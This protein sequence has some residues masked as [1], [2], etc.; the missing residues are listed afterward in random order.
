MLHYL[1]AIRQPSTDHPEAPLKPFTPLLLNLLA[2]SDQA[3]R[4]LALSTSIQIFSADSVPP[5]A[6]ADLK[7]Q[8]LKKDLTKKVQ[9]AILAGVLGE[10]MSLNGG[11]SIGDGMSAT[12]AEASTSTSSGDSRPLVRGPTTIPTI[13]PANAFP[14]EPLPGSA[15]VQAIYIASESDLTKEFQEMKEGFVGKETEH[16]W[17][18]R[19]K[20]I[21]RIRGMIKGGVTR[22]TFLETFLIEFKNSLDGVLRTVRIFRL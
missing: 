7:A 19:D 14:T 3:V 11:S 10:K 6:K 18:V 21:G 5:P 13:L 9:D 12:G 20:S 17:M 1:L 4:A 8:L 16:N 2:D 15:D 22:G